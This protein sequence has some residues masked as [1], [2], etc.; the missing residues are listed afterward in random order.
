MYL[1]LCGSLPYKFQL[2]YKYS[3]LYL[4]PQFNKSTVVCLD[5]SGLLHGFLLPCSSELGSKQK[6]RAILGLS[7]SLLIKDDSPVLPVI[8][9]CLTDFVQLSGSLQE[10]GKSIPFTLSLPEMEIV[11]FFFLTF[12]SIVKLFLILLILAIMALF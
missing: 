1:V 2:P 10:D 3:E 9:C 12:I 4:F 8:Q 7:S 6:A 11:L 5:S